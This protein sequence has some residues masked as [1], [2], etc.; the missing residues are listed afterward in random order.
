L[1]ALSEPRF[2]FE[3]IADGSE[4]SP[5]LV[6]AFSSVV[7]AKA[8]HR[9]STDQQPW[10]TI[11]SQ[12]AIRE[13]VQGG[14]GLLVVHGGTSGYDSLAKMR[15]VT[16]GAFISHSEQCTVTFEPKP[17]HPL[18]AGVNAFA[19][20]DEHY[21]VALDDP[22]AEVFLESASENGVQPAGWARAEGKG[23]V[24]VL[25]PGHN[26]EVWLHPQFQTLLRNGL[27]WVGETTRM[28]SKPDSPPR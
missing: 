18:T 13:Y 9:S 2:T 1:S 5:A 12:P 4:W 6:T 16:G 10:L 3:F 27:S 25:T 14:G 8:N 20:K 21:V 17:G 22:Q 7:I 23:R 24:C 11:N 28:N 26:V 19:A 15:G